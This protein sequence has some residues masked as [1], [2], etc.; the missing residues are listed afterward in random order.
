VIQKSGQAHTAF[1]IFEHKTFLK[2]EQGF[3]R[4]I[5]LIQAMKIQ[6]AVEGK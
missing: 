6:N 5:M 2:Q 3:K 4:Q 1:K